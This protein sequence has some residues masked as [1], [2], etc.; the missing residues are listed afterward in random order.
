MV[1]GYVSTGDLCGGFGAREGETCG[2]EAV[3]SEGLDGGGDFFELLIWDLDLG[4]GVFC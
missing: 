2:D 4:E 1:E 3:Q